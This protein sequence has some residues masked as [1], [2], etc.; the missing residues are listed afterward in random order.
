MADSD[1]ND[2]SDIVLQICS[3]CSIEQFVQ[4]VLQLSS[5]YHELKEDK[6]SV[7]TLCQR[8]EVSAKGIG[9]KTTIFT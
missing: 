5:Q 6:Y 4:F 9:F 8:R 2:K 7:Q 3:I 1:Q